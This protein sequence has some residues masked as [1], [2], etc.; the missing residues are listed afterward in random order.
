MSIVV[1]C[2]C[3][4][5]F[6][7]YSIDTAGTEYLKSSCCQ[8]YDCVKKKKNQRACIQGAEVTLIHIKCPH[9]VSCLRE[10][11]AVNEAPL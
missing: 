8:K 10:A 4:K 9:A 6:L 1:V 2:A 3:Q 7:M 5:V 11:P